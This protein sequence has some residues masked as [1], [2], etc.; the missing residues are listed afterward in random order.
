MGISGVLKR[1]EMRTVDHPGTG[2][3]HRPMPGGYLLRGRVPVTLAADTRV[4]FW[5]H[6][7]PNYSAQA[8]RS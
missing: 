7:G 3:Q 8:A 1:K 4:K 6:R 2:E 5:T